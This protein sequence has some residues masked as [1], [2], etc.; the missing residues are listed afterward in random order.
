MPTPRK[1]TVNEMNTSVAEKLDKIGDVTQ[2]PTDIVTAVKNAQT[3]ADQAFQSAS[4]G[5]E[6][7][8]TAITG[9]GVPAS[10]SDTFPVL[11]GKISQITTGG[12]GADT[13]DATATSN[14]LRINKT[15]YVASGKVAGN[16]VDNGVVTI[17]P[18]NAE[19]ALLG[20]YASGSKVLAGIDTSDAIA[21]AADMRATKT[22]YVNGV[23]VTGTLP[24]RATSA[25]TYIPQAGSNYYGWGIYDGGFTIQG[26]SNLISENIK[27]T[28]TIFG[29]VGSHV[30][31]TQR[32]KGYQTD[33]SI[34]NNEVYSITGLT[35]RAGTI[36]LRAVSTDAV[37]FETAYYYRQVD[38]G[39]HTAIILG[40]S[41]L[42][43]GSVTSTQVSFTNKTGKILKTVGYILYLGAENGAW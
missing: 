5:R 38:P 35:F 6:V 21:V 39:V 22:A 41:S 11:A 15:A 18:T 37:V 7:V 36:L 3:K 33:L 29:V 42:E 27:A 43:V 40:A 17:T 31:A 10:S 32:V 23:K 4:D 19:Q 13:S 26:D 20:I 28:K 14:D 12:G 9:K 2:L 25:Q 8:A 30:C 24:V 16:I 1:L 34:A